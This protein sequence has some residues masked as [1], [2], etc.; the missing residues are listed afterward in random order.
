VDLRLERLETKMD[1]VEKRLA[2]MQSWFET[3][4]AAL[5]SRLDGEAG[6]FVVSLWGAILAMLIAAAFALTKWL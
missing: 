3:R 2:S 4:F 6:N 1:N 5:E